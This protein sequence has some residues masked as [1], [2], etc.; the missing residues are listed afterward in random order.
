[1]NSTIDSVVVVASW[2]TTLWVV[3]WAAAAENPPQGARR[4]SALVVGSWCAS[5]LVVGS[6]CASVVPDRFSGHRRQCVARIWGTLGTA[7]RHP[8]IR[9]RSCGRIQAHGECIHRIVG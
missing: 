4:A 7:L 8:L 3:Y 5:A 2:L 9:G 6:W 1:M